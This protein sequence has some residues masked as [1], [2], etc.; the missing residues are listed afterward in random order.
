MKIVVA[1][2]GAS[3]AIYA[4]QLIEALS[5]SGE[6]SKIGV[7]ISGNGRSVIDYELGDSS[8]LELDMVQLYDNGDFYAPF[9]SGSG[10]WDAMVVVP[11]S[12]GFM[13]RVASGVG[14]T[15]ML[16]AFD[17]MLKER[18]KAL[19][20]VRETPYNLIHIE[21]MKMATLAGATI[22]PAS[23]SLYSLPKSIEELCYTV[24][25]RVLSLLGIRDI[26]SYSWG[27]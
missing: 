17:V 4:K 2:S 20:V 12:V 16:R 19:M 14:D 9:A 25:S 27:K 10:V 7:V 22:V 5:S 3:G 6:V 8:F 26:E 1:I 13:G 21:N 23:P 11:C 24:T 18:R 15:L